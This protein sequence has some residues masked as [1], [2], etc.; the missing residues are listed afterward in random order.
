MRLPTQPTPIQPR[1][2]HPPGPTWPCSGCLPTRT[3]RTSG[4]ADRVA[5]L[6]AS[7]RPPPTLSRPCGPRQRGWRTRGVAKP[8][9]APPDALPD[10][11]TAFA[12]TPGRRQLAYVW[13][14]DPM[15]GW[16]EAL[17][18]VTS[19]VPVSLT[20]GA[21]L[22]A[23]ASGRPVAGPAVA[24]WPACSS[25]ACP[26]AGPA[27]ACPVQAARTGCPVTACP[28]ADSASACSVVP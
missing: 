23:P 28:V 24:G 2:R 10:L 11:P 25:S 1:P 5:P 21:P 6:L 19:A 8:A 17:F 18:S 16:S 3:T 22:A 7:G 4:D 12:A 14:Q 9:P 27:S 26:V 15:T 13:P 20:A